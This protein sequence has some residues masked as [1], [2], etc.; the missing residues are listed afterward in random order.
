MMSK[1][2]SSP[3]CSKGSDSFLYTLKDMRLIVAVGLQSGEPTPG[4]LLCQVR[5]PPTRPE[6]P[7][8][9]RGQDEGDESP[10]FDQEPDQQQGADQL[11]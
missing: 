6:L 11:A 3:N 9:G 7:H 1:R 10:I 4:R 2:S 5:R 8:R